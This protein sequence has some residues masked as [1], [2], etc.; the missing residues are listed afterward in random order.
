V[1]KTEAIKWFLGQYT[2]PDLAALY[3]RECE[4]QVSVAEDGGDRVEG[5]FKGRQWSAW[6]DGLQTWKNFR[7]PL[8]ANT[9]P[10]DNDGPMNFNLEAHAEGI[11]LTGWNW[12]RRVSRWV[13]FDFDAITGH[14]EGHA[15]KLDDAALAEVQQKAQEIP[16]VTVRKST[17]GRGIHLYVFLPDVPTAN[18]TEHA[19]LGRAVLGKMSAAVGF[20]FRARVDAAGGNMWFWHRKMRGTGGLELIKPGEVLKDIPPDWRDHLDVVGKRRTVPQVLQAEDKRSDRDRLFDEL[21]GQQTAVTLEPEHQKLIDYLS[22]QRA[23]WS[24]HPDQSMLVCHTYWL[25]QAH[26][27]LGLKGP[28][29]T[30]ST[31]RNKTTDVNCFAFPLRGGAWVVRRYTPGVAE[32]ATWGKDKGGWTRC[33]LNRVPGQHKP[34]KGHGDGGRPGFSF[35]IPLRT[36]NAPTGG[37]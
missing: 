13:G 10:Q 33:F 29:E 36:P 23:A 14:A 5:E 1:T 32:A 22:E 11:G 3:D 9:D 6:T 30:V 16:W 2:H 12:V 31:G 15:S 25:K 4:V 27:A 18:H 37:H 21:T 28:F 34:S 8:N 17:G 7:I 26:K 24:W 35:T 20:D 19:A